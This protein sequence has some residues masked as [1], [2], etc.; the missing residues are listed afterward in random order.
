F[1]AVIAGNQQDRRAG[2][3]AYGSNRDRDPAIGGTVHRMRQAQ[4]PGLSAAPVEIDLGRETAFCGGHGTL[5]AG[6]YRT[7]K[8]GHKARRL[9]I[10]AATRGEYRGPVAWRW[11][12]AE[13]TQRGRCADWGIRLLLLTRDADLSGGKN[14]D[15]RIDPAPSFGRRR[16]GDRG[17]IGAVCARRVRCRQAQ[18]RG[19]GP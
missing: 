9:T 17:L 19:L 4:K 10:Q 1:I 15:N 8:R 18:R 14:G 16:G 3:V 7:A 13:I 11:I 5:L 2:T 12:S 6:T